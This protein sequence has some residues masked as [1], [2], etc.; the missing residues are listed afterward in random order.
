M[1]C[2]LYLRNGVVYIP[3]MGKMGVGFYRDVEPVAVV[4]ASDTEALRQALAAMIARGNP[5]VPM[6][7]RREWSAPVVLKYA[8]VRSWSAFE[9]GMSLWGLDE[10]KNGQFALIGKRKK[11]NGATVD[12]PDKTFTFSA[13]SKKE[14]VIE[15]IIEILQDTAQM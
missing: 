2:H 7:Q 15:K 14:D 6:L 13:G 12:D 10:N 1:Y 11:S 4:R 3:T 5:M 9:Q 8:G